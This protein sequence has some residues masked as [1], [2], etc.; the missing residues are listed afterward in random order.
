MGSVELPHL[1]LEEQP[2]KRSK[3]AL[4]AIA[5]FSFLL[6]SLPVGLYL[7][8]R[9]QQLASK[10]SLDTNVVL[11]DSISLQAPIQTAGV[12][13]KIP[14]DI[15]IRS[16]SNFVNLA[17]VKLQYNPSVVKV[18][19][20][21]TS[22][23]QAS[24]RVFFGKYWLSKGFNNEKGEVH[25]VSGLPA[26]GLQTQPDGSAYLLAQVQFVTISEGQTEISVSPDSSLFAN[27]DAAKLNIARKNLKL[28]ISQDAAL[29]NSGD[30]NFEGRFLAKFAEMQ[31]S[32]AIKN[33]ISILSPSAGEVFFYFRPVEITWS[34]SAEEIKFITL[35]LNGEPYGIIAQN[36][37]NTGRFTWTP[38]LSIPLPMVVP[39]NTYALQITSRLKDGQEVLSEVSGPFGLISNPDGKIVSSA[40]SSINPTDSLGISDSS[41]M[42]RA[43]GTDQSGS[44]LDLNR[45]NMINYLDWYLLRKELFVKDEV[46]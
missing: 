9:Q 42:L 7:V 18:S 30:T 21:I 23:A 20:I 40:A 16:D 10:A 44:P 41:L 2:A 38:S 46:Y 33:Q 31:P 5:V 12:N 32:S 25:L 13:Q 1:H 34:A 28:S 19:E 8:Q 37:P 29:P 17:D 43:W 26:P 6:L 39:Q 27:S 35:I 36:I 14:V 3:K 11:E 24:S 4:F 45:D 22:P 15:I